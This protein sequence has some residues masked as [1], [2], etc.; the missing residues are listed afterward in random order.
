MAEGTDLSQ[1][2]PLDRWDIERYYSPELVSRKMYI[3]PS[4]SVLR[5]VVRVRPSRSNHCRVDA[6]MNQIS[7]AAL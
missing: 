6:Y 2:V 5:T 3:S 1:R 7:K 4:G